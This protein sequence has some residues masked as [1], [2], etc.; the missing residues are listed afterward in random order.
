MAS[1]PRLNGHADWRRHYRSRMVT[2]DEAVAH[3]KSG[4]RVAL[5]IAQATPF[6]LCPA[7]AARLMNIEE[8][9]VNHGAA[10]ANWDLPGLG[11]RFRLESNYLTP[12]DRAI[13]HRGS[14]E[15]TPIAYYR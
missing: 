13:Y 1:T 10:L 14:G 7:L 11:E 5:S 9:V 4:D 8:V 3:I 2:A 12:F 15:F 6:T